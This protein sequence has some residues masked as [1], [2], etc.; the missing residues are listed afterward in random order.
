MAGLLENRAGAG[1]YCRT[2][3]QNPNMP[4]GTTFTVPCRGGY[5]SH[6][7]ADRGTQLEGGRPR[8]PTETDKCVKVIKEILCSMNDGFKRVR[9]D[10]VLLDWF[11]RAI[12]VS[13]NTITAL[14]A[15]SDS[16]CLHD[17]TLCARAEDL[18][19]QLKDAEKI[20][21]AE[22]DKVGREKWVRWL[23]DGWNRGAS[24]AHKATKADVEWTA[25]L[26]KR[27]CGTISLFHA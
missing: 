15:S 27:D 19:M 17:L 18:L 6:R 8:P 22:R 10:A 26:V 25:T 4:F 13:C 3:A 12:E 24:N 21:E 11:D 14:E 23:E 16:G 1:F 7:N 2:E 9:G 20:E 5:E